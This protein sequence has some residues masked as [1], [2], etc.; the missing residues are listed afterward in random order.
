MACLFA[1]SRRSRQNEN[2][3]KYLFPKLPTD[4]VLPTLNFYF[5]DL[6]SLET[7]TMSRIVLRA[8][9]D[10]DPEDE[11]CHRKTLEVFEEYLQPDGKLTLESA[12]EQLL[13]LL[14]YADLELMRK[15]FN[16][17][18]DE[19]IYHFRQDHDRKILWTL[20]D[21]DF[22]HDAFT[23]LVIETGRRIPF[24]HPAQVKLTRLLSHMT[25]R[26]DSPRQYWEPPYPHPEP[27]E[28]ALQSFRN[29]HSLRERMD[30]ERGCEFEDQNYSLNTDR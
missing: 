10:A 5:R 23:N 3:A 18:D 12:T 6:H 22:I 30:Q 8:P 19:T 17:L 4:P 28:R 9:K 13:D 7:T 15:R 14:T 16:G 27:V 2:L 24:N 11:E 25:P 26:S 1:K 20:I 21:E 29:G